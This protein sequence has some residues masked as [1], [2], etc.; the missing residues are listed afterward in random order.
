[1]G[2]KGLGYLIFRAGEQRVESFTSLPRKEDFPSNVR[3]EKGP[4]HPGIE[5]EDRIRDA[6]LL[7]EIIPQ[8]LGERFEGEK[9]GG[10]T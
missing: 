8:Y 9:E 7:R 2:S 3:G 10:G 1:M 5:D 4:S 6:I